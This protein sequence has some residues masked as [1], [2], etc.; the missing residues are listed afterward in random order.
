MN[1]K[2]FIIL[3]LYCLILTFKTSVATTIEILDLKTN[4]L[5]ITET[6]YFSEPDKLKARFCSV[7]FSML[8]DPVKVVS[9]I[10]KNTEQE[11][12]YDLI[13][14]AGRNGKYWTCDKLRSLM[15]NIEFPNPVPHGGYY[16]VEVVLEGN[17]TNKYIYID[18][19]G[20]YV[21]KIPARG[22]IFFIL[23]PNHTIVFS[24]YPVLIY[25][26]KGRTVL[27]IEN[28]KKTQTLIFK[29]RYKK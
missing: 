27:H 19:K 10:E 22:E 13:P 5:R 29:T 11:L 4:L 18:K 28:I 3:A 25:E 14:K 26:K 24:N 16:S 20:R 21:F 17:S 9:I 7:S 1:K 15:L 23:P 8:E 12:D 2:E 6:F